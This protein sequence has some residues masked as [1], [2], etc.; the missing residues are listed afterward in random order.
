MVS[1][2]SK[3]NIST[4]ELLNFLLTSNTNEVASGD[5]ATKPDKHWIGSMTS[6][7]MALSCLMWNHCKTRLW[8]VSMEVAW[9]VP[10]CATSGGWIILAR[11]KK[12][13]CCSY[14][15]SLQSLNSTHNYLETDQHIQAHPTHPSGCIHDRKLYNEV[16]TQACHMT[17]LPC[18]TL[19]ESLWLL[20]IRSPLRLRGWFPN[21]KFWSWHPQ[22]SLAWQVVADGKM[23]LMMVDRMP[24]NKPYMKGANSKV[25]TVLHVATPWLSV[26]SARSL[27]S[28][29]D[30][31]NHRLNQWRFECR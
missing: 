21:P 10:H 28:N 19:F 25:K 9:V 23:W 11:C 2:K 20:K 3:R 30:L 16:S 31:Q 29:C 27:C 8:Q 13:R 14:G 18:G 1:S 6:T 7:G 5:Q 15:S 4:L 24:S 26:S 17:S 12:H 22:R